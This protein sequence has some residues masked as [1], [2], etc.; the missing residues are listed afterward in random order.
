[1]TE[2]GQKMVC[3]NRLPIQQ[4]GREIVGRLAG[5]KPTNLAVLSELQ[6]CDLVTWQPLRLS[7]HGD[8]SSSLVLLILTSQRINFTDT[9]IGAARGETRK[10]K[11]EIRGSPPNIIEWLIMA[12][13]IGKYASFT[14]QCC[15]E[16]HCDH[17]TVHSVTGQKL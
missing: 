17:C 14:H 13:V 8:W 6:T 1:M 16:Q 7:K 3:Q 15:C 5:R 10:M 9:F 12:W 2:C 4:S 11:N